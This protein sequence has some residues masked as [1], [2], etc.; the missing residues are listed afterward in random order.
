[1]NISLNKDTVGLTSLKEKT[2]NFELKPKSIK[3][4]IKGLSL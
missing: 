2:K 3:H 1:M 4:K